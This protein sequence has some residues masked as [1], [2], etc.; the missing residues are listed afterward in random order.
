MAAAA[1]AIGFAAALLIGGG[2]IQYAPLPTHLSF[3]VL[4][5][6]LA[7]LFTATWF[8]PHRALDE[9]PSRWR[10]KTPEIP[11][12]LRRPFAVAALAV[13]TAY[14]HGVMILSLGAQVAH[15]L[16]GSSN[17]LIN[18]AALSLFAVVSGIVGILARRLR[19]R[20]AMLLGA[21]ASVAG[22]GL[23]VLAV[24]WH[25]LTTFLTATATAG[26]GY[27]L[28]FLA[29]LNVINAA[30]SAQHRGGVLSAVY[31]F[32]YLSLGVVALTL[33]AVATAWGLGFAIRLGAAAIVLLSA[34]TVVLVTSTS[35]PPRTQA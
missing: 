8:L 30:A 31:L 24:A 10:F 32:A 9:A 1:Q 7:G 12:D 34:I 23:L 22:M 35:A 28:L 25:D 21:S 11:R 19:T 33:G 4:F 14:T 17:A 16:V 3:W 13:T 18:G 27:S 5:V 2:L 26:A 6:I 15:D 29:G 20:P